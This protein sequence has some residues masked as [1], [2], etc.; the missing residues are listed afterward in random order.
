MRTRSTG[1]FTPT[2]VKATYYR[3][4]STDRIAT[5]TTWPVGEVRTTVDEITPRFNA[6]RN[7]GVIINN[8]FRSIYEQAGR[9]GGART[10][11]YTAKPPPYAVGAE[12]KTT[13]NVNNGVGSKILDINIDRAAAIAEACT[14]CLSKVDAPAVLGLA[15]VAELNATIA[16]LKNP[17]QAILK[18]LKKAKK[19]KATGRDAAMAIANQH[20][21]ILY[22][23]MPFVKDI[24]DIVE[25]LTARKPPRRTA[26]G[27]AMRSGSDS[28]VRPYND[29]EV[30]GQVTK[31][32][33]LSFSVRAYCLYEAD[34]SVG[35]KLGF[36]IGDIPATLLELTPWSFVANWVLNLQEYLGA[37]TPR[38]GVKYLAQGYTVREVGAVTEQLGTGISAC[39]PDYTASGGGDV[40][41]YSYIAK[42]RVPTKP[43][44]AVGIVFR[45]RLNTTNVLASLSLI[46]QQLLK[47]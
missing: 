43:A 8:R 13:R 44:D 20:L 6:L 45:P 29:G 3:Y 31:F 17:I 33:N 30:T 35:S 18:L 23:I 28:R 32:S 1:V 5:I 14:Q 38:V 34:V 36:R 41:T 24:E 9:S 19:G 39:N 26:R 2:P 12:W 7:S 47:K 37:L 46:T 22:G 4:M 27:F 25:S 42:E 15:V 16:T 11:T 21:A 40:A 10:V